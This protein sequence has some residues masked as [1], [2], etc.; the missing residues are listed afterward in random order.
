MPAIAV[1]RPA[2]LLASAR[3]SVR[4]PLLAGQAVDLFLH[5]SEFFFKLVDLDLHEV[6]LFLEFDHL[7][8][9][10]DLFL[11]LRLEHRHLLLQR[12]SRA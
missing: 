11:K 12:L 1:L 9:D 7:V 6:H 3:P 5:V 2:F 8:H 4:L 10:F